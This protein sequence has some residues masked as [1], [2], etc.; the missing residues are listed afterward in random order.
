MKRVKLEIDSYFA[1]YYKDV[2]DY[3][4]KGILYISNTY[5]K[6]KP[7]SR[8]SYYGHILRFCPTCVKEIKN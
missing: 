5:Y 3:L 1:K 6:W 2:S 8:V 7:S 4:Q